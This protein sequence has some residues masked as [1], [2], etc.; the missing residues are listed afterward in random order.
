MCGVL[1]LRPACAARPTSRDEGAAPGVCE[2]R[3]A[4]EGAA[5]IG[6]RVSALHAFSSRLRAAEAPGRKCAI[7]MLFAR[8]RGALPVHGGARRCAL[9]GANARH[10][11]PLRAPERAKVPTSARWSAL[12]GTCGVLCEERAQQ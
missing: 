11:A 5:T 2:T 6:A 8:L 3:A 4:E 12:A 1:G 9:A 7:H 10:G